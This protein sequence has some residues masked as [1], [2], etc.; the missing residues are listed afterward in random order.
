MF[1][2]PRNSRRDQGVANLRVQNSWPSVRLG[3]PNAIHGASIYCVG[4]S[5]G[6]QLFEL[7]HETVNV[8]SFHA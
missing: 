3:R 8:K 6:V 2:R 1:I 7:A 4:I 5:E